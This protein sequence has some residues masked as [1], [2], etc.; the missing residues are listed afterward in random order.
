MKVRAEL[1]LKNDT[2]K[3]ARLK[4]GLTQYQLCD[5]AGVHR[6][7]VTQLECL[8]FKGCSHESITKVANALDLEPS[9]VCPEEL[10]G[11]RGFPTVHR[12]S[13]IPNSRLIDKSDNLSQLEEAEEFIANKELLSHALSC[14][15]ERLKNVVLMRYGL[16]P[17]KKEHTYED[18]GKVLKVSRERVRQMLSKAI[19]Q[20]QDAIYRDRDRLLGLSI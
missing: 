2:L 17:Y 1:R 15:P 8:R 20:M 7:I 5:I 10:K 16:P 6:G 3:A 14:I 19:W 9:D 11:F 12:I 18:I 4:A 13:D